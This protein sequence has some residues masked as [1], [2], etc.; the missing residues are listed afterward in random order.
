MSKYR[1]Y[2]QYEES[3]IQKSKERF[4]KKMDRSLLSLHLPTQQA[5]L[6]GG[7]RAVTEK[8]KEGREWA[9]RKLE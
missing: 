1:K 4:V 5:G 3:V 2:L 7:R 8:V 6:G 9:P